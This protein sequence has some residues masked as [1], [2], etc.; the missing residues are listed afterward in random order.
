MWLFDGT[1]ATL[2]GGYDALELSPDSP[3]RDIKTFQE[4]LVL[5]ARNTVLVKGMGRRLDVPWSLAKEWS[6]LAEDVCCV[7]T[8]ATLGRKGQREIVQATVP[9]KT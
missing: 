5:V 1:A 7:T 8:K 4:D 9:Y 2:P 6:P 3:L